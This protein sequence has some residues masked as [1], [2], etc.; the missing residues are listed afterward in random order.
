MKSR[1]NFSRL[2]VLIFFALSFI[3]IESSFA[4]DNARHRKGS[5]DQTTTQ[6]TKKG[7]GKAQKDDKDSAKDEKGKTEDENKPNLN[8]TNVPGGRVDF[9]RMPPKKHKNAPSIEEQFTK[10]GATDPIIIDNDTLYHS[11]DGVFMNGIYLKGNAN[12]ETVPVILVHD[13]EGSGQDL[14]QFGQKLAESGMAVLIPDLRGHGLC[15]RRTVPDYSHGQRPVKRVD[16]YYT[17]DNFTREDYQAMINYD[18]LFWYQLLY[19]F[20]N[21][22]YLNLRKLVVIGVGFG[23]A[24][25]LGWAKNDWSYPSTKTGRFVKVLVFVS[26]KLDQCK[27]FVDTMKRKRTGDVLTYLGIVGK[28]DEDLNKDMQK[29]Q[30]DLGGKQAKLEEDATAEDKQEWLEKKRF[31]VYYFNTKTNGNS[32]L[33]SDSL[34]VVDKIKEYITFRLQAPKM[35]KNFKWSKIEFEEK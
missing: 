6:K 32:I 24:V 31:P 13:Y 34:N 9:G 4:A 5:Q 20:H 33:A 1:N 29:F 28:L 17:Y 26:P 16:D 19:Q 8:G 10:A 23:S 11:R 2:L 25:G 27:D 3:I 30:I 21:K 35:V 7:R 15:V 18:G 22:E 12:Q 14:L